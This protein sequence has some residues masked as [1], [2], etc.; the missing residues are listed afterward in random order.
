MSQ[1]N[2]L[3]FIT[4]VKEGD[5]DLLSRLLLQLKVNLESGV[6][7]SFEDL[8]SIHFL[9]W[10]F[11]NR[12]DVDQRFEYLLS[13]RLV[14]SVIYDGNEEQFL[15]QLSDK[16]TLGVFVDDIYQHCA[17]Y[18]MPV[19]RNTETRKA[20]LKRW[21]VKPAAF[22]VGAPGRSLTEIRDENEL[23]NH[24]RTYLNQ[25]D[26]SGKGA[27]EVHKAI[28]QQVF[29]E[30]NFNWAKN[31]VKL[32]GVNWF[33]MA[34]FGL[35]LLI[36]VPVITIWVLIVHFFYERHDKPPGLTRSQVD[37]THMTNLEEYEDLEYQ[38]QFT[39]LLIMKPGKVRLITVQALM[40]FTRF[41]IKFLFVEGK[42]MG[43]PTIHFARWLLVDDNKH[44]IFFS[45]FD[46]SWQQYLGD[47]IDKSGWGLTAI[48]TNTMN[49]PTTRYLFTGGAYD[50]E[51]FLAWSRQY[52]IPTQVWYSA[53]PHLSI[54]NIV[55]NTLI[56]NELSKNLDER[57]AQQFLKRF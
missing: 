49:F 22:Y 26:F 50:E 31:Q 47:F 24:I 54:K 33:V 23:R 32:Q 53:Y 55:N 15:T 36:L 41:L 45:N 27:Q 28:Q 3:T 5:E 14:F 13:S 9:R 44:M 34:L 29:S 30:P 17:G 6:K 8:N 46:G 19:E 56:R 4:Q 42:L 20:Y 48:W 43:I 11:I 25:N 38:N 52:E 51:H 10:V 16:N 35:L 21:I 39:Q 40:L 2:E 1:Q 7:E 12:K 18:P 37:E 57:Q